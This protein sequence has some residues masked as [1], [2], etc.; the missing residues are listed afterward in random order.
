MPRKSIIA[1]L[2]AAFV[3]FLLFLTFFSST[4]Y[5][6]NL[7]RVVVS[8]PE[9][10]VVT[11]TFQ[12]EGVVEPSSDDQLFTISAEFPEHMG[13][14]PANTAVRIDIPVHGEY[15]LWGTIITITTGGQLLGEVSFSS[16][17]K[18]SGGE[19]AVI[20]IELFSRRHA[21]TLP[22]TAFFRDA[23]SYYI[24]HITRERAFF[25]YNYFARQERVEILD[26]GDYITAFR[27]ATNDERGPI[28]V[29]SDRFVVPDTRV[30]IVDDQ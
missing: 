29:T 14:L 12:S 13:L 26:Q 18:I 5:S 6:L 7:P 19:R 24:L 30:R 25:G 10:G 15:R 21:N 2:G 17:S 4:L 11:V 27:A 22:N 9:G 16:D 1:K 3:L 23:Q 8:L 20:T 28:I